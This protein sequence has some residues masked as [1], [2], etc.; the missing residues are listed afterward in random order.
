MR[1]R[2]SYRPLTVAILLLMVGVFASFEVYLLRE[3]ERVAAAEAR[4]RAAATAAGQTLYADNCAMCHGE[5]GEGVDAPPLNDS[6]FLHDTPDSRIFSVIGSGVPSTEMPA[7]NQAHGGPFTDE[8]IRQV[9]AYL[10]SWEDTAPDRL[11][12][13]MKGDP[14]EGLAVYAA[15]CVVCHGIEGEGTAQ[16]PALNDPERLAKFD[17]EWY[18]ST[19]ADG[20]PAAGM[21][22]WGTVLSPVQIRDLVALLRAWERGEKVELPAPGELLH[23]ATHELSHGDLAAVHKL[24]AQA[25]DRA[26]GQ[27]KEAIE[28]AAAAAESGDTD[29]LQ[30]ALDKAIELAGSSADMGNM[31]TGGSGAGAM[32]PAPG[33][34]EARAGLVDLTAGDPAAALPKLKVALALATGPLKETVEHA[35]ADIEAGKAEE[36]RRVL[37]EALPPTG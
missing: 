13:A 35:I 10:R 8:E 28:E 9:V 31:D 18:A 5:E 2:D 33:E 32:P 29:A 24:L 25:A 36:A 37:E 27:L 12:E 23:E 4:D 16:G 21:P 15:T 6:N 30:Q 17:D 1:T 20:R 34:T 3:P 14:E 19:I 22:T 7:W 26:T 11:A